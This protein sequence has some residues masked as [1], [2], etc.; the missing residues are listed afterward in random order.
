MPSQEPMRPRRRDGFPRFHALVA[1]GGQRVERQGKLGEPLNQP[2]QKPQ[3]ERAKG[4]S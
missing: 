1:Q 2:G 3:D 4:R